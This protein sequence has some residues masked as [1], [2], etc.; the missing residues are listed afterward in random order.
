MAYELLLP[1]E[2]GKLHNVFHPWLLHLHEE[3]P[4]PGQ[5]RDSAPAEFADPDEEDGTSYEVEAVLDSRVNKRLKDPYSQRSSPI[6]SAM[7]Q[8][9]RRHRQPILGT[10]HEPGGLRRHCP[11]VP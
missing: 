1:P 11:T 7:D 8:L 2:M 3:A 6:L 4:L 9:P 5:L 10:I